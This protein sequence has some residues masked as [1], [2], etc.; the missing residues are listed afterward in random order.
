M[1]IDRAHEGYFLTVGVEDAYDQEQ[2][3]IGC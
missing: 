2:I 1:R 3:G